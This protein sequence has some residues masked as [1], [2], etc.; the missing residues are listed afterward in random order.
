MLIISMPRAAS[1]SLVWTLSSIMNIPMVSFSDKF[2][3][4]NHRK[5][6]GYDLMHHNGCR[7]YS[8]QEIVESVCSRDSVYRDHILPTQ[9]HRNILM[10]IPTHLRKVVILKR[11]WEESYS[12]IINRHSVKY[13]SPHA[14]TLPD[15]EQETKDQYARFATNLETMFPESD[16]FLHVNYHDLTA[17]HDR[18][19]KKILD[20]W[21]FKYSPEDK[22]ILKTHHISKRF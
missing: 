4:K 7:I 11:P 3:S 5:A 13:G 18:S 17:N 1:T 9:E 8:P 15:K 22:Y 21:G 20:Y 14:K 12:S 16:G 10:R 19:I 6:K 2:G